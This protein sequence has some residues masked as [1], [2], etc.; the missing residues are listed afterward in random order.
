M[1][2]IRLKKYNDYGIQNGS[3]Y[4]SPE[5]IICL[6]TSHQKDYSKVV[7]RVEGLEYAII[8]GWFTE[9]SCHSYFRIA[10]LEASDREAFKGSIRVWCAEDWLTQV[11]K[12]RDH[13]MKESN[14]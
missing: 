14:E 6:A 5:K 10:E 12:K 7:M 13:E 8:V 3:L 2:M 11:A 9:E 4:V 1:R